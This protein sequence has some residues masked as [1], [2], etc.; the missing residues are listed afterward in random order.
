MYVRMYVCMFVCMYVRSTYVYVYVY[1]YY[2]YVCVFIYLFMHG[3][4]QTRSVS[5]TRTEEGKE[6]TRLIPFSSSFNHWNAVT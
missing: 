2:M 4:I 5:G 6:S 3:L 1:M